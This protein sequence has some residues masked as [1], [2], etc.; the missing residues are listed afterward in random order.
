MSLGDMQEQL[1]QMQAMLAMQGGMGGN[2]S[3]ADGSMPSMPGIDPNMAQAYLTMFQYLTAQQ[4]LSGAG[5]GMPPPMPFPGMPGVAPPYTPPMSNMDG[6]IVVSVEGMKFQYQLTEDD[7][8]KVF[9][10]YGGVKHIRVDDAGAGAQITFYNYS[11][12]QAAMQDLNGKVLNGLE[13][14]LRISMANQNQ[15]PMLPSPYPSM[16]FPNMGFPFPGTPGFPNMGALPG[17]S[18]SNPLPGGDSKSSVKGVRKYTCRFIIGIENDKDFQVARRVI[19]AKG[20]NMKRI[21]R[22]TEA[23]LRLRGMGSG[24]CEGTG[25][26]ESSE[27]LQLCISCTNGDHYKIAVRQVEDLLKKVYEEYRAFCRENGK[28]IPDLQINFSENQL[29]YSAARSASGGPVDPLE[30]EDDLDNSGGGKKQRNR[31]ARPKAAG[32]P[33]GEVDRGEP[34]PLAPPVDE[35]EKK[36]DERNEARRACNFQEA[37]RIRDELHNKGVALM[38]EPG[39]RGQG[40]E[41]TTWRYW[42]D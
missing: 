13:G 36:I 19:G 17:G 41:V 2:M 22:Q 5:M 1:Q 27:P 25:Q 28:P 42:R 35:I 39:G 23:K 10:R 12:A 16:P 32:K 3:P 37:D 21:V 8:A 40:Q 24:Y 26:K 33:L 14:T 7:L 11:D 29:V 31:R 38:D 20:A 6:T 15:N 30:D 18:P 4:Q 9:S 34:G